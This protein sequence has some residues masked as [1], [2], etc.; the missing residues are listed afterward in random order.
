MLNNLTQINWYYLIV[1]E[2]GTGK[3]TLVQT[4]ILN[5]QV[6]KGVVHFECP[7]NAKEFAIN[8]AKH[9]NCELYPHNLRDIIVQSTTNA[10]RRGQED[11]SEY[12]SFN[13][14][15]MQLRKA[16][17]YYQ[18]KY[19][20]PMVLIL[21]QVDRIAKKDHEFFGMLQDFAKDCADGGYLVIIFIASEG[22]VPQM[23]KSRSAWSRAM[24]PFEVGDISDEDAVKFLQNSGVDQKNAEVSVKYL[25]GGRFTLLTELRAL[26]QVNSKNLFEEFKKRLFSQIK[27]NLRMVEIPK[28]HEFFIKLIEVGRIDIEQAETIIPIS[29]IHK[30]VEINILKE[31]QDDTVS[32]HSRCVETYFK[33]VILSNAAI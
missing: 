17:K 10:A 18:E 33:E 31:H 8:L 32:F 20:R 26:N 11:H 22:L 25:A 29:M 24:I 23:M 27:M 28:N 13:I 16:A 6:P 4:T 3:T 30:L 12:S 1:G 9:L 14:L 19:G 21:D 15:R 5:L 7:S 2:H